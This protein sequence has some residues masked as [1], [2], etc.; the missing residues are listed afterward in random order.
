MSKCYIIAEAGVNHNG[1][2]ELALQLV[3]AAAKSGADAVKFQ[4]FKTE[5]LVSQEAKTAEYQKLQTG[6]DSQFNMLKKLE[7]S[8]E[9]HIKLIDQCK[10]SGIEFLSTPFDVE[11]AKFLLD[12]GMKKIKVSSGELT[13]IPFIKELANYDMPMIVSTGM[14]TLAEIKDAVEAIQNAREIKQFKRPLSEMLTILHCTS[15]YPAKYKDINLRAMQTIENEFNIPVGYSDHT[16][17]VFVSV[18]AV[19]MGATLIEKHFTLGKDMPG[20][21]HKASLNPE[22][23]KEMVKQ[24]RGVEQCLG[25]GIKVPMENEMPI[26]ALVRRSV[27]LTSD[28]KANEVLKLEDLILLRPGHGVAPVDMKKVVGKRLLVDYKSGSTLQWSDLV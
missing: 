19:A 17:G 23:L 24:I 22:E 2:D 4:T 25:N 10:Q 11:S 26:R 18:S 16:E 21:D 5:N 20:P 12:L 9:L 1:S 14:S 28:K 7:I 13:N 6:E 27:V 15:N 3:E 8:E